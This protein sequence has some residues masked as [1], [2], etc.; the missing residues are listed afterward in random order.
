LSQ[1]IHV[2]DSNNLSAL[3]VLF[4]YSLFYYMSAFTV[5]CFCCFV[6]RFI[7]FC[8]FFCSDF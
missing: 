1:I 7:Q 2:I 8:P 3:T 4:Y 5:C 6:F